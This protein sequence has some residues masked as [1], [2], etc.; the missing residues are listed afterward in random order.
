MNSAWGF[1]KSKIDEVTKKN[2]QQQF[3]QQ[4]EELPAQ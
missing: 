4:V 1:L 3:V 2:S